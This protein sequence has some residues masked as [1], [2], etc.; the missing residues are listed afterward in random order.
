VTR[1]RAT[2]GS[3]D[4]K[5]TRGLWR[6]RYVGADGR[7]H[8]IYAKTRRQAQERLREA[9]RAADG[10]IRPVSQQLTVAA[11]LE[12][13]LEHSVKPARRP[14]THESYASIVR[15]YLIPELGRLPLAKLQPEHVQ[16]M[17]ARLRGRRGELSAS[18]TRYV[19]TV[20]RIALGRAL[21]TGKVHRNVCSLLDP[22][23]RRRREIRPLS[24][25]EL[26]A[27][28]AGLRGDRLEALYVTAL[29][30]GLRQGELL[31]LRWQDVDLARGELTV[32]HTLQRGTLELAEPKTERARRTIRLPSAV[33]D[34][35]SRHRELQAIVPLSGL[36][37]TSRKGT[38][39]HSRNVTQDLQRHLERLGLPRQRFHDLRHAF[40]TV[41]I[42]DGEELGVVSRILGHSQYATTADV[43]AHLTPAMLDRAAA[44]MDGLLGAESL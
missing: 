26:R 29:G 13:W 18:T 28:L 10:G 3:I 24:R 17:L 27:L 19:Y 43:Y 9:L 12:D 23:A 33:R 1:R 42:E 16:A 32:R 15:L 14:R 41:L 20:L 40:A 38:P 11:F 21:K 25:A 22:P 30:T 4:A 37:F 44:R 39:L 8:A 2:G 31:A 35:L 7:R 5:P 6:A 36:V 34:A